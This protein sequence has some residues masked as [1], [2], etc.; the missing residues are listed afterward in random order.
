[1]KS[2]EKPVEE[3]TRCDKRKGVSDQRPVSTPITDAKEQEKTFYRSLLEQICQ[4][5]RKTR[6]RRLAESGLM[7][8]DQ[9]RAES[10]ASKVIGAP[11]CLKALKKLPPPSKEKMLAQWRDSENWSF[12]HRFEGLKNPMR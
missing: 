9:I 8:W 11:Q 4:D 6:A 2:C 3:K 7:F 10:T 12:E 1:M 5:A